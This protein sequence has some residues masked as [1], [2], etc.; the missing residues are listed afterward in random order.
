MQPAHD[1]IPKNHV[2][3]R[4]ITVGSPDAALLD[5]ALRL[6]RLVDGPA[7]APFLAPLIAWEIIYRLWMGEQRYRLGHIAVASGYTPHTAKVIKHLT[8][9]F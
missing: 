2:D 5:A 3:V 6:A 9:D 8:Q 1:A 7:E 4:A